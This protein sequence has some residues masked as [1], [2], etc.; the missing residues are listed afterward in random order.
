MSYG[1]IIRWGSLFVTASV[2]LA[3][4]R[5]KGG[6]TPVDLE[7]QDSDVLSFSVSVVAWRVLAWVVNVFA[8]VGRHEVSILVWVFSGG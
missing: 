3:H 6:W 4:W 2:D 8:F 7:R 1:G 5:L